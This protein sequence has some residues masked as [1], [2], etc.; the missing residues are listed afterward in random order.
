MPKSSDSPKVNSLRVAGETACLFAEARGGACN[1]MCVRKGR[2]H[3]QRFLCSGGLL[4]QS[5]LHAAELQLQGLLVGISCLPLPLLQI[6]RGALQL[7]FQLLHVSHQLAMP[8]SCSLLYLQVAITISSYE[9]HIIQPP[10]EE[11]NRQ[12]DVPSA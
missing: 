3:L 11:Y 8:I 5:R 2:A 6:V 12:C 9:L 7:A 10:V 4:L 1:A